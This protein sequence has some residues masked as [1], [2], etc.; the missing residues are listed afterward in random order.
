MGLL[1]VFSAVASPNMTVGST[2]GVPGST[3]NVPINF[4]TDI[5]VTGVE[6][7]LLFNTNYLQWGPPMQ[8]NALPPGEL[9]GTNLIA[10]GQFRILVISFVDAP[11]TN[12]VLVYMPFTISSNAPDHDEALT[13]TNVNATDASAF[14]VALATTN[15]VLSVVVPPRLSAIART[16]AGVR[17]ALAGSAGR[18][19]MFQATT[20]LLAP[21]WLAFTNVVGSNG[22]LVD[23]TA[24]NFPV[25]FY[26]A[27]V[28]P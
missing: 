25:R 6:F 20:N 17:L 11:I 27:V 8:G 23:M 26:R 1:V 4:F 19:Y 22:V 13:F 12:G 21:Q 18:N 7:D 14:F 10:P 15:G 24:S 16:N 9:M 28:G 5:N 3:I 2:N